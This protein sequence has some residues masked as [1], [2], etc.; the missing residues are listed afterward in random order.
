MYVYS[1]QQQKE[2]FNLLGIS[3]FDRVRDERE[4]EKIPS[5]AGKRAATNGTRDD[6]QAL[7]TGGLCVCPMV[8]DCRSKEDNYRKYKKIK[9]IYID[10]HSTT[11]RGDGGHVGNFY[12]Y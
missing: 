4:R 10:G 5:V 1:Y 9:E 3:E 6:R 12:F 2:K 8:L 11:R 7:G